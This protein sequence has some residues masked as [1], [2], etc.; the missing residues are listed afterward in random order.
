MIT[1]TQFTPP[2]KLSF[3]ID[4]ST[5]S[6]PHCALEY[7]DAVNPTIGR[8]HVQIMTDCD[9]VQVGVLSSAVMIGLIGNLMLGICK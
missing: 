1:C 7:W 2:K 4:S 8:D 5:V 3:D 9:W 6:R